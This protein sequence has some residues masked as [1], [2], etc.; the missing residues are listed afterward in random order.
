MTIE[1]T[2]LAWKE[3]SEWT[4]DKE[5]IVKIVELIKSIQNDPFRGLGKPEPLKFNLKGCW[6]RRIN[7]EHRLIYKISGKKG[8]NQK[9]TIIQCKFHY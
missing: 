7:K 9:C 3:F 4:S 6:S 1:F 2:K 5:T 8:I